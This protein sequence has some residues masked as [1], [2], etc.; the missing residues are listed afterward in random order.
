MGWEFLF[1][2]DFHSYLFYGLILVKQSFFYFCI[3]TTHIFKN[4]KAMKNLLLTI[5]L[6]V[7]VFVQGQNLDATKIARHLNRADVCI[8]MNYIDD[9]IKEYNEI[10][11]IAPDWP[12]IYMYLANTYA[13][14]GDET[15]LAKAMENYRKFMQMT[16]DKELYYEAQ[17]KLSRIEM[18][19]EIKAKE[20]EKEENLVGSW[21]TVLHNRYT[22]QPFFIFD[23]AKT[24]VPNKYQI[25]VSPKS[26]MY[27][28]LINTKAYAEIIDGKLDFSYT[29]QETYIPSQ[30]LYNAAGATVNY[31]F[32]NSIAGAVGGV[33]VEA[34]REGDVGYTNIMDFGFIT[35]ANVK[36]DYYKEFCDGYLESSCHMKGEHHQ[37]GNSNVELDTIYKC[38]L[39][40]GDELFP[41]TVKVAKKGN[42]Y[43]YGDIKLT[44]YN[45]FVDYSPYVSKE[46]Y[47]QQLKKMK[48]LGLYSGLSVPAMAAAIAGG[49]LVFGNIGNEQLG[50]ALLVTGSLTAGFLWFKFG[51]TVHNWNKYLKQSYENHNKQVDENLRKLNKNDQAS[52][53]VN[54][55]MSPTG[56]GI[57]LN[58]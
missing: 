58:F 31:L 54:V 43:Y 48:K 44:A 11:K 38:N 19:T 23:I 50:K 29:F 14:K 6:F 47:N 33:L 10:V 36:N 20:Q 32:G 26:L 51:N 3:I 53:F 34:V 17:N 18:M 12:N 55:G 5:L 21:R 13:L 41:V 52:V 4:T 37:A 22:G 40:K 57:Y 45:Q 30:S 16:D 27:N 39:L 56:A 42:H 9:A 24:P 35:D 49:V 8:E 28:N 46:E 25:I 7:V 2:Q 1:F 15:S